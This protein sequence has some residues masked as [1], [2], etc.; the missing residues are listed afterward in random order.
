MLLLYLK[1]QKEVN[2]L[3]HVDDLVGRSINNLVY[4]YKSSVYH[5]F[6]VG[7]N[8]IIATYL[9]IHM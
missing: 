1:F 3:F 4:V 8:V 9:Y 6:C 5:I 7:N 2:L